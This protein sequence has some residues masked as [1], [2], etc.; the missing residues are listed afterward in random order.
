MDIDNTFQYLG[1]VTI[2]HGAHNIKIG[3]ALI[4]RQAFNQ[5]NNYGIGSWTFN[6]IVDPATGTTDPTGLAALLQGDFQQLQR[7]N[8]LVPP[9]YRTW[10]PSV[11]IQDDWHATSKLTLNLGV[12]Y[13]VFTPFTEVHNALSNFDPAT[14][15]IIVAGQNG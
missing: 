14:G 7:S 1:A 12:R 8:S 10:E 4:R 15:T 6:P 5:Q 2:N 13:D 3:A 11:Y 9:H